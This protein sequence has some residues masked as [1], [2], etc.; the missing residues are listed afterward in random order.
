MS[1]I[2]QYEPLWG[3]WHVESL[4][5]E[6]SFGKVY[7][8]CREEF[9]KKYYS[10]VKIISI[11]QNEVDIR[12]MR[13]E[14]LD[15][16]SVRSY[17]H[18]FV[19]DIIKE[20]DLMSEFRGNSNI[21]SFEDH[22]VIEKKGE[23]GW[24]ILIRMEL[25]TSLTEHVTV[26]PLK[27]DEVTKLGIHICRALELCALH[28]TIHRDIKPDNIFISR[29]G[30]YKLGDFGIAR[31]IERTSSG[32]SKK[33]TY[34]YM[35]PE[36]FK[37]DDY[38]A[39]VDTYSLGIVMYRFLNQN[40]TPFLPDFPAAI[41][42]RDRD[43]ALQRRMRGEQLPLI[44]SISP[45]LNALV[46][47]ACAYDRM[48]RFTSATQMR[49][50]LESFAAGKSTAAVTQTLSTAE[51]SK[52]DAAVMQTIFS[53]ANVNSVETAPPLPYTAPTNNIAGPTAPTFENIKNIMQINN[54]DEI[55]DTDDD[56][57]GIYSGD[58]PIKYKSDSNKT[59]SIY[60]AKKFDIADPVKTSVTD[61]STETT[62][63]V[64][65]ARTNTIP[66]PGSL[67]KNELEK[68]GIYGEIVTEHKLLKSH[69]IAIAVI[70]IALVVFIVMSSTFNN[71]YRVEID[72]Y[73]VWSNVEKLD[74]Q[75]RN[76]SDISNIAQLRNLKEL[77]LGYNNITDISPLQYLYKLEKL[78]LYV[79]NIS[80]ISP[81]N[82]LINLSHLNIGYN[83]IK[84]AYSLYNLN[85]LNS[86]YM[87]GNNI[88][89]ID[90]LAS[91]RYLHILNLGYNK[92]ENISAVQYLNN[93][94]TLDLYVNKIEDISPL[95]NLYNLTSLNLGYNQISDLSP[96]S[97][98]ANLKSLY[99]YGNHISDLNPISSLMNLATLN[100]GYNQIGSIYPLQN[101]Q[102]LNSLDLY[103]NHISDIT[104]LQSMYQLK[105][106]NL[107]YNS[108]SS[109]NSL[110]ALDSLES[111]YLYG[112]QINDDI[113]WQS[114]NK[115]KT[116]DLHD[117]SLA[118]AQI[119]TIKT[120][121]PSCNV[122][123]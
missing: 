34:T 24:D 108:I 37:G 57:V 63:G 78:D 55:T 27:S 75:N 5:G 107:G 103:V 52:S 72:G 60:A 10:A 119:D 85:K 97:A 84:N 117:T 56:T 28:N 74:L 86:L 106:L 7:K 112:N 104:P 25:L 80:D 35:A 1:D 3:S 13:G 17:F 31:Q 36:V 14:G 116:L 77:N 65:I 43:A 16:A 110:K 8:V 88:M 100:L 41:T 64:F 59:E 69:K 73:I 51:I 49:E 32:L 81:I 87:Y 95:Q 11:P 71:R 30:D 118:A 83:K 26:K 101:M 61:E 46:V 79:N 42:P 2:R 121:L 111:L 29:Y 6:G 20:I 123:P 22:K 53:V 21:V 120:K 67:G 44:K 47:K 66:R 68:A 45:A 113:Y 96:L 50:S 19:A 76:I 114:L 48:A 4:I 15:E 39:S 109:I 122:T 54:S 33:G 90:F 91:F 62:T 102:R 23:I 105:T 12:Q 94:D 93:L 58:I 38:G 98:L 9:G 92:I 115:L 40:R 99:L 18:A 82:S 70:V 89:S